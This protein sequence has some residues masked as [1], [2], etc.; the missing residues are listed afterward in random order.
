MGYHSNEAQAK[1]FIKD[2]NRFINDRARLEHA[3]RMTLQSIDVT[4]E[5]IEAVVKDVRLAN[6]NLLSEVIHGKRS[7]KY[8]QKRTG[9]SSD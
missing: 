5:N 4:E 9:S 7:D 6:F 8:T 2:S 1:K 3:L